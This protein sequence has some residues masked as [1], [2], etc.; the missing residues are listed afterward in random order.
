LPE[1]TRSHQDK[2]KYVS[3]IDVTDKILREPDDLL[4]GHQARIRPSRVTNG[5][6][7]VPGISPLYDV[8]CILARA[9]DAS[10]AKIV[11]SFRR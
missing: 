10:T 3:R 1:K 2:P 6:G 5:V 7:C 8:K 4:R 9:N 11:F